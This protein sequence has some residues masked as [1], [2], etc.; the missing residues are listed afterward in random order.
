MIL[1]VVLIFVLLTGYFLQGKDSG[2]LR[3]ALLKSSLL[4]SGLFYISTELLST[5]DL[6]TTMYVRVTWVIFTGIVLWV[7]IRNKAYSSLSFSSVWKALSPRE[8]PLLLG[9]FILCIPL[10]FLAI[11]VPTNNNDSL[12]YH[13]S[14]VI[15]WIYNRDVNF[16]PTLNGRLLYYSP[17]AEYI[18]LQL[19]LLTGKIWYSNLPQFFSM[20]GSGVVVSLMSDGLFARKSVRNLSVLLA[21]TLPIG[22]FESTTTQNDYV[23]TFYAVASVFWIAK[24]YQNLTWGNT[25]F[26]SL[27]FGFCGLTKYSGW[28][29]IA[30]FLIFYTVC[31]LKKYHLRSIQY[32]PL[33][34]MVCAFI[35]T[36]FIHRNLETFHAPLG[37]QKGQELYYDVMQEHFGVR[38]S[39]VSTVKNIGTAAALPIP[40]MNKAIRKGVQK[41]SHLLGKDL[42]DKQDNYLGLEYSNSFSF[43][44]DRASNP[45]HFRLF[46]LSVLFAFFVPDKRRNFTYLGLVWISFILFSTLF[47][48]QPWHSRMELVWWILMAPL[49]GNIYSH[50]LKLRI[51]RYGLMAVL[52]AYSCIIIFLN[53]SKQLVPIEK[54][55]IAMP[56]FYSNYDLSLLRKEPDLQKVIN[57]NTRYLTDYDLNFYMPTE[58]MNL[59][60]RDKSRI[61]D[62]LNFPT[63]QTI[64]QKSYEER[65]YPND[66]TIYHQI[67]GMLAHIQKPNA[68]IAVSFLAGTHEFLILYPLYQLPQV[69]SI[70]NIAYPSSLSRTPHTSD[71][72]AYDYLITNNFSLYAQIDSSTVQNLY[73][74]AYFRLYEFKNR[75]HK[76]YEVSDILKDFS[77]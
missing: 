31:I 48:W 19:Q 41:I 17:F 38:E 24:M 32:V 77:M 10:F 72:Y 70:Q 28:V 5:F 44:E 23:C 46:I 53:P 6:L 56:S 52:V 37:P 13:V 15:Y 51:L 63:T 14:R 26:F 43:F 2:L 59:S 49:L 3:L 30:P 29:F 9:L 7:F 60:Q 67:S 69:V 66:L 61:I 34:L 75:Q 45:V 71:T 76:K 57:D 33:A 58:R 55:A 35:L 42:N 50:L 22:L 68:R 8:N 73:D 20:I 18:L 4:L 11:Y 1:I 40:F 62:L 74:F 64:F 36:P 39:L 54:K 47:K 21:F 25:F 12:N 65:M 16:F 27:A